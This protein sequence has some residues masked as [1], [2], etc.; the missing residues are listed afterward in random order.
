MV[1]RGHHMLM[2][3]SIKALEVLEFQAQS[4]FKAM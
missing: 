4:Y 1:I 3:I 2:L